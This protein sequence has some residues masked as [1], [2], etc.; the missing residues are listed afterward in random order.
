MQLCFYSSLVIDALQILYDDDDD[1]DDD[2]IDSPVR[3]LPGWLK[4]SSFF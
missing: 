3:S 4:R 2:G 1:D